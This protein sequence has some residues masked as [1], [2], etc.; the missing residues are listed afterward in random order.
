M[1]RRRKLPG[2]SGGGGTGSGFAGPGGGTVTAVGPPMIISVL[3]GS[4]ST[5][6]GTSVT[7]TGT[8]L[9]A[10]SAVNFGSTGATILSNT[11][12]QIVVNSPAESAGTV[13]V[14]VTTAAGTATATNAFTYNAPSGLQPP[15]PF[16]TGSSPTLPFPNGFVAQALPANTPPWWSEGNMVGGRS[17]LLVANFVSQY[18]AQTGHPYASDTY[19]RYVLNTAGNPPGSDT[20]TFNPGG[21]WDSA[22]E[23]TDAVP[24]PLAASSG[25][26]TGFCVQTIS[27]QGVSFWDFGNNMTYS[28]WGTTITSTNVPTLPPSSNTGQIIASN[29]TSYPGFGPGSVTGLS[30]ST[31]ACG[32]PYI[33][34]T[35]TWADFLSGS[36]KHMITCAVG[37]PTGYPVNPAP[38][39]DGVS[40]ETTA[41]GGIDEGTMFFFP[42]S[43]SNPGIAGFTAA[44]SNAPALAAMVFTAIQEYCL[45]VVDST[46]ANGISIQLEMFQPWA[47]YNATTYPAP[48][49]PY[50]MADYDANPYGQGAF[51]GMPW[52]SM[53]VLEPGTVLS[54]LMTDN[55]TTTTASLKATQGAQVTTLTTSI[56]LNTATALN[57][58]VILS[59]MLGTG[60]PP[61]TS[62]STVAGLGATWVKV[63]D[64]LITYA[65]QVREVIVWL[66]Y[67]CAAGD[68]ALTT[69]FTASGDVCISRWSGMGA[70][71]DPIA[72]T[73]E[74]QNATSGTFTHF[75]SPS[76]AYTAGQ[77][78]MGF[79][80]G[81]VPN[82]TENA[83]GAVS[84]LNYAGTSWSTG[85]FNRHI[86]NGPNMTNSVFQNWIVPASSTT[87]SGTF[88]INNDYYYGGVEIVL[89]TLNV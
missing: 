12:A 68:T 33:A 17:S 31:T 73:A 89:M 5:S 29:D 58:V 37:N 52:S 59:G 25:R 6:G 2:F 67:G 19:P 85:N 60:S 62:G 80:A 13:N 77:I 86:I 76:I 4:G 55:N 36:I 87:V 30:S 84:E 23:G 43:V 56:S 18:T 78:V 40:A 61:A 39:S 45:L 3:P 38:Q 21:R 65:G 8:S 75:S 22:P 44:G 66:G 16:A 32:L 46:A 49:P 28:F 1:I 53:E 71:V 64:D 20:W 82:L 14:S 81:G 35:V 47:D 24:V 79:F 69:V 15:D 63:S 42:S 57:D 34:A 27:D 26:A 48:Q 83:F 11:Y 70:G 74:V 88:A 7:I 50:W 51:L 54:P 41:N 10:A 9:T 72:A